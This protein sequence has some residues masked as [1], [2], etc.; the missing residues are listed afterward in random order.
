MEPVLFLSH[1]GGPMPL[2]GDPGHAGLV[3][4]FGQIREKLRTLTRPPKALLFVSAHWETSEPAITA[5]AAPE[6]Y[7][8]YY[9][10][11]EESYQL[12]YP[13]PGAPELAQE[14][15]RVLDSAGFRATL[16]GER[17]LDHG[18][19]VP[20]LLLFPEADIPCLQLSLLESLDPKQHLALG[21]ALQGLRQQGVMMVGSG[22]SFHNMRAFFEKD[23]PEGERLN[24]AFEVWLA[25]TLAEP[26]AEV[27]EQRLQSWEQ[28]P[29]AR[30]CHPRE[31]HLMPV[32]VCAAAAGTAVSQGWHFTA[33]GRQGSCY[34]WD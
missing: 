34:W 7:F 13:V 6:L 1:G 3:E 22:F 29:G 16:N 15:R 26:S 33:L 27:R 23:G 11:P 24:K 18:V 28:A 10:F 19:F 4:A 25:D 2:L 21:R 32:H 20:A 30:Y 31:E 5:A 8:D 14:L 9:G 12:T 17:G